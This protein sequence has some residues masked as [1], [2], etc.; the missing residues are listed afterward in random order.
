VVHHHRKYPL[1]KKIVEC[2]VVSGE[3][4]TFAV[5]NLLLN[6]NEMLMESHFFKKT[7]AKSCLVGKLLIT[8]QP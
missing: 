5:V 2:L 3:M 8:L 7:L 4:T 6:L 1:G